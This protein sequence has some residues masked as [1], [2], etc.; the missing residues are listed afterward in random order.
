MLHN[1]ST[2][3]CTP[4]L[5]SFDLYLKMSYKEDVE[6]AAGQVVDTDTGKPVL[7]ANDRT[8]SVLASRDDPFAPREGKTL[9]WKNINMTLVRT[10]FQ[11]ITLRKERSQ[12]YNCSNVSLN[13]LSLYR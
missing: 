12:R 9:A 4:Q 7:S 5:P 13:F 8:V 2:A 11:P 3:L 10:K 1:H 6:Y